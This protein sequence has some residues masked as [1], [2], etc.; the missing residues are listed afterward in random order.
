MLARFS[1]RLVSKA[2]AA[3]AFFA[4][5][6]LAFCLQLGVLVQISHHWLT[7]LFAMVA[8]GA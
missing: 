6:W 4:L 3:A 1:F 7:T 5:A 2:L 8:A